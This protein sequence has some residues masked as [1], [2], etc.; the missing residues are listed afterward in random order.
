M[1]TNQEFQ[2]VVDKLQQQYGDFTKDSNSLRTMLQHNFKIVVKDFISMCDIE[3]DKFYLW[4]TADTSDNSESY[5]MMKLIYSPG[6]QIGKEYEE[7]DE[8][9]SPEEI[10]NFQRAKEFYG[11][12]LFPNLNSFALMNIACNSQGAEILANQISNNT[13]W[14]LRH[15]CP[16]VLH[17]QT[18]T[19]YNGPDSLRRRGGPGSPIMESSCILYGRGGLDEYTHRW[20]S[21]VSW[22][23]WRSTYFNKFRLYELSTNDIFS[24]NYPIGL[25]LNRRY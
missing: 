20:G 14:Q 6:V 19:F 18:Y 21:G 17:H 16:L 1:M 7:E 25:P 12:E 4:I 2:N 22:N 3:A 11:T 15:A 8:F 10:Q 24:L 9:S 13:G 5:S 23:G